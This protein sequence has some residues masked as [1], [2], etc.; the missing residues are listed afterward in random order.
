ML[1][2][3]CLFVY[4]RPLHT[5]RVLDSL[6]DNIE[7]KDSIIYIFADGP[8]NNSSEVNLELI[9]RT[10]EVINKETRLPNIKILERKY[11]IGLANSII[12][13]VTQVCD[14]YGS[15]IVLEDDIVLTPYS[16]KY[17]ND[18]LK[19]Y[20]NTPKVGAICAY[21]YPFEFEGDL[22]E[23]YFLNYNSCWGWATWK[24]SW[25]NFEYDSSKLYE[26]IKFR[27]LSSKFDYDD[28]CYHMKMLKDHI[29]G[30]N[31][32]WAIRWAAT[33]FLNDQLSLFPS[34]ALVENI[35]FDGSGIHSGNS[36]PYS[37]NKASNFV[38]E[39]S[40]SVFETYAI[41]SSVVSFFK[42]M[43]ELN[44]KN[45]IKRILTLSPNEILLKILKLIR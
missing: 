33:L 8:P 35:G 2:P 32:S 25:D 27:K 42:K 40:D 45:R 38:K 36:L 3:I 11:N 4:N 17:F 12:K 31:N 5:Q 14:L 13:G 15:V 41:R 23:T 20:K 16:L 19:F 30:R 6:V 44:R 26:K 29:D 7:A 1:A 39:F 22:P 37:I 9:K 18:A 10:R 21:A 24:R 43:K 34:K 28:S